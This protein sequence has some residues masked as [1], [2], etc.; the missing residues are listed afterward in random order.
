MLGRELRKLGRAVKRGR[1]APIALAGSALPRILGDMTALELAEAAGGVAVNTTPA[2]RSAFNS[3]SR[4]IAVKGAGDERTRHPLPVTY[5]KLSGYAAWRVLLDKN[6]LSGDDIK[7]SGLRRT[8]A[9]IKKVAMDGLA[10]RGCFRAA[11]GGSWT[12]WDGFTAPSAR[13]QWELT[14]REYDA[15]VKIADTLVK[16]V[17]ATRAPTTQ[18]TVHDLR[19]LYDDAARDGTPEA[20]RRWAYIANSVGLQA[21]GSEMVDV[22]GGLRF[23]D[24]VLDARGLGASLVL[25]KTHSGEIVVTPRFA[26]HL[27]PC[28][29]WLCASAALRAYLGAASDWRASWASHSAYR[30]WPVFSVIRHGRCTA[31]PWGS[32]SARADLRAACAR[33]G[34]AA[35]DLHF[36]RSSGVVLYRD[37]LGIA[38]DLYRRMGAHSAYSD[39]TASKESLTRYE[40]ESPT[41]LA[42]ACTKAMG[43]HV[44]SGCCRAM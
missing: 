3:Y 34:I 30:N 35:P 14:D 33:V 11:A 18:L 16:A 38:R 13:A 22:D 20:R 27:P 40:R 10:P 32:A 6:Q 9:A 29:A 23:R 2:T 1:D 25:D 5:L 12:R 41:V 36:G 37:E 7:S 19:L 17:P 8:L 4:Y 42:D 31:Q 39:D 24:I 43:R 21:R 28:L 15:V 44:V 26:P